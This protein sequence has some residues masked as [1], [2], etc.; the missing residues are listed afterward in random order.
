MRQKVG[1]LADRL[2]AAIGSEA[3]IEA[4]V[5]GEASAADPNDPYFALVLDAYC[6]G[7]V[8][9]PATR[10]LAYGEVG[11]LES[12]RFQDK[13][14]FFVGGLPVRVE[15]KRVDRVEELLGKGKDALPVLKGSGTYTLYRLE[16]G[17]ILFDRSGWLAG[18]RSSLRSLP[19][20][21]W[22]MLLEGFRF[23]MEHHLS[24]L[25]AASLTGDP[26]F[27]HVSMAGFLRYVAATLFMANR[28]FE[29]SNRQVDGMVRTLPKLPDQFEARWTSLLRL[30]GGITPER[31]FGIAQ[32]L[33]RSVLSMR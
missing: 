1:E 29:P 20:D 14:R 22:E 12:S 11:D 18:I 26:F 21:F 5:L 27:F 25:G 9:E 2:A 4:I 8:P 16:T 32:L 15:Y 13:D 23:K 3:G 24:D 7:G 17:P 10:A 6:R 19:A 30:D 28:R 33:A 31:A